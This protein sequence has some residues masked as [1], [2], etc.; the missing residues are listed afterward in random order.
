MKIRAMRDGIDDEGD[1]DG[2]GDDD[3]DEDEDASCANT[4]R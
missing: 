2:Y 1:V 3:D 4:L